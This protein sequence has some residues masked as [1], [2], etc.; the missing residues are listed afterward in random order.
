M[1]RYFEI[2]GT[3][4]PD[5][6][7]PAEVPVRGGQAAYSPQEVQARPQVGVALRAGPLKHVRALTGNDLSAAASAGE[8]GPAIN[9]IQVL[10][11]GVQIFFSVFP[12]PVR[13]WSREWA[14]VGQATPGHLHLLEII[15]R[16]TE[17]AQHVGQESWQD[18]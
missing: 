13:E 6:Q 8:G 17:G 10:Y 7:K 11:D 15:V 5:E 2:Q 4:E 16:D 14:N 1:S 18:Q 12:A 9:V 3:P